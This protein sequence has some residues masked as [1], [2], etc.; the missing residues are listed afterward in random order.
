M[1][2]LD[3]EGARGAGRAI[4]LRSRLAIAQ[5]VPYIAAC[6]LICGGSALAVE[7]EGCRETREF[8]LCF[9]T[10]WLRYYNQLD[11][12]FEWRNYLQEDTPPEPED[13]YND[14]KL[15]YREVLGREA[16]VD[17]L[18]HWSDLLANGAELSRVRESI[19]N[20]PESKENIDRIYQEVLGRSVDESGLQTWTRKLATGA[21]LLEIRQ[22]IES[23]QEATDSDR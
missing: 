23:S 3:W 22:E 1:K 6:W 15:I 4:L 21:T 19:A 9:D 13:Y 18:I 20:S 10:D 14:I 2:F 8:V 17:G 12:E 16:D 5:S 11:R 7:R